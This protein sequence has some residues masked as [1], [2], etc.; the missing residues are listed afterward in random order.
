L[1]TRLPSQDLGIVGSNIGRNV[2]CVEPTFSG[3]THPTSI[4]TAVVA[5]PDVVVARLLLA[6]PQHEVTW[7]KKKL[8][9]VF[10]L[11]VA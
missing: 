4:T 7:A 3:L 6:R 10:F 2:S 5:E 8:G 9:F 1:T 11:V